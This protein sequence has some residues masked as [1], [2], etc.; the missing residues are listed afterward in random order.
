[1]LLFVHG[2]GFTLDSGGS[3]QI[4]WLKLIKEMHNV[5][6]IKFSIFLVDYELA[7]QHPYPSQIIESLAALHYLKN[8]LGISEEKICLSGDSAGGN[9]IA[10][11][12]LHLA[13]PNP[14]ISL[15]ASF[16]P[17][18]SRPGVRFSPSTRCSR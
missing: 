1:M 10:G 9:I 11:L 2:G 7:P 5:R 12:L 13:R 14:K 4:F 6:K 8:H 3:S 16:G 18:P 15:P 17:T